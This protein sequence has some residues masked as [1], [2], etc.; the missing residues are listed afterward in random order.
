V[1]EEVAGVTE[2]YGRE[3]RA[4]ESEHIRRRVPAGAGYLHP[5]GEQVDPVPDHGEA[6]D[7]KEEVEQLEKALEEPPA[8]RHLLHPLPPLPLR[9]INRKPI[10][11]RKRA[12]N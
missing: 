1:L 8:R 3:Q 5:L 11:Q 6:G 7:G 2:G 10:C 12:Q 4:A 9:S